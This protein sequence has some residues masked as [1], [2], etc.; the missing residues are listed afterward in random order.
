MHSCFSK[1][2]LALTLL[3]HVHLC[4]LL[5]VSGKAV[6]NNQMKDNPI[7][8]AL[9]VLCVCLALLQVCLP[10]FNPHGGLRKRHCHCPSRT[11]G[12]ARVAEFLTCVRSLG[13]AQS[14]GW[15]RCLTRGQDHTHPSRTSVPGG[16]VGSSRQ[17]PADCKCTRYPQGVLSLGESSFL[18]Y[19]L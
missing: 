12:K 10:S 1:A 4:S 5:P 7:T 9:R 6:F 15:T 14:A 11:K 13:W 8:T 18:L 16:H 17:S 3:I 19:T 2:P